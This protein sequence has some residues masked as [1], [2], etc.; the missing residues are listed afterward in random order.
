MGTCNYCYQ[1]CRKSKQQ[2]EEISSV[3]LMGRDENNNNRPRIWVHKLYILVFM[4]RQARSSKKD[5]SLPKEWVFK[6]GNLQRMHH[7]YVCTYLS[8]Q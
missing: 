1:C 8:V 6:Q 3:A 4:G 7:L 5:K 2:G